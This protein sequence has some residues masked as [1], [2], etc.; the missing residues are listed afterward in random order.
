M[1]VK[2][3]HVSGTTRRSLLIVGV[4][5]SQYITYNVCSTELA[6]SPRLTT[7]SIS[8]LAALWLARSTQSLWEWRKRN[9]WPIPLGP[10]PQRRLKT[11]RKWPWRRLRR[12]L[13]RR[14]SHLLLRQLSFMLNHHNKRARVPAMS[15]LRH[16]TLMPWELESKSWKVLL[17]IN[18]YNVQIY[19][20]TILQRRPERWRVSRPRRRKFC[21]LTG[22][23]ARII[24][25][26]RPCDW[27][28]M[29]ELT[30]PYV[31]VFLVKP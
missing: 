14:M 2:R 19:V 17:L 12:N 16:P 10:P 11:L 9:R 30:M 18:M 31:L 7:A 1:P 28:M 23:L 5:N 27:A 6:N 20:L 21:S 13:T 8:S 3:D 24:T 4:T 29:I 22:L 15:I 26:R 25:C